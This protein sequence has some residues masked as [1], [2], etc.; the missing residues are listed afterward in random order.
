MTIKW[1]SR[2]LGLLLLSMIFLAVASIVMRAAA[3]ETTPVF[4]A[5]LINIPGQDLTAVRVHFEP[6]GKSMPHQHSGSVLAYVL[7]GQIRS[8]NSATGPARVYHAGE[9][10]FEPDGSTHL[11][12]DNASGTE[13]ADL[14][15]VFVAPAHAPLVHGIPPAHRD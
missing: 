2:T 13:P 9:V 4:S 1:A 7:S 5:P 8:Q 12:C 6:G 14:L 15:A 10:F 3:E 11:V